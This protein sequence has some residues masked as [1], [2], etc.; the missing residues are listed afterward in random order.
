MRKRRFIAGAVALLAC[1]QLAAAC[2]KDQEGSPAAANQNSSPAAAAKQTVST[3]PVTLKIHPR[4]VLTDNDFQMLF[5]DPVK[6]K[7]PHITLE[8]VRPGNGTTLENLIVSGAVPD[9]IFT[10]NGA[11]LTQMEGMDLFEDIGPLT[12][13]LGIKLDRFDPVYLDAIKL[14]SPK[15]ELYALPFGVNF[16]ALYYNKDIFDKFGVPYPKDG[17]TWN[18]AAD[19]AKKV[20][21]TDAGTAYFG[22]DPES[23]TRM[24]N[25]LSLTYVDAKSE[26]ATI[27]NDAWKM[28]FQL[29]SDIYSIPG[30]LPAQTNRPAANLADVFLRS[31]TIAMLPTVNILN[32]MDEATKNGLSWDIVQY[33]S[34]KERPN[35]YGYPDIHLLVPSKSSK[36]QDQI[37]QVIETVTSDEVQRLS[38]RTTG[39]LTPLTNPDIKKSLGA[40]LPF[41]Q[42]KNL[43]GIF[44]SKPAPAPSVS[45][46]QAAAQTH[47]FAG[48]SEFVKG[49]DLNTVLREAE[50]KTNKAIETDKKK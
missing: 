22:L 49:K 18:D 7:Y 11:G 29:A 23:V 45:K 32:R 10:F 47:V 24:G 4:V 34:F 9:I 13:K 28:V 40:D 41:L 6:K 46:Y 20:T 44:K 3:E 8:L 19:I 39:R 38:A 42:G 15:S 17:L 30:N 1:T 37:M 2:T 33:P 16:N 35:V 14:A 12:Q 50:E 21:K 36:Y 5:V 26:K 31:K 25:A 48:F 27:N 43:D